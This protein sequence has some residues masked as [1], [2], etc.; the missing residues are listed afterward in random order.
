M[1]PTPESNGPPELRPDALPPVEPPSARFII[2]LFVIPFAIVL[3]LV[4]AYLLL[5]SLPFGRLATGGDATEYVRAI[6]QGNENRRWRSAYDL[7]SLIH[8]DARLARDGRLLGELTDLL[9]EEL[10][11]TRTDP[12]V[13]EFLALALG[14]FQTLEAR[15]ESGRP[16][17]PLG[18]LALA[19]GPA[20]PS[21]VRVA[22]AV[23]ISRQAERLKGKLQDDRVVETLARATRAD[24]PEVRQRAAY[25]LGYFDRADA[26][27][28]LRRAVAEDEDRTVRYN[29]AAALA[30]LGDLDALPVLREMLSP[31]DLAQVI[32]RPDPSETKRQIEAIE[33]EAVWAI[34]AANAAQ[35]PQLARKL[36]PAL[37]DLSR[38]GS[39]DVRVEAT[40]LLKKLPGSPGNP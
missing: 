36:R 40:A 32:K 39:R 14:S 4:S 7:A 25:A 30:R 27:D 8:N 5:V 24:D 20:Q 10:D 33:L 19:L 34:Q 15:D 3:V 18:V 13:A 37:E 35:K 9:A 29:A 23:T 12:R 17:D 26:R 2:Q 31:R 1:S 28:A 22:A 21:S 6:R 11:R 16:G 38:S